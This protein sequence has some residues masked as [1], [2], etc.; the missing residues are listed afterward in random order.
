MSPRSHTRSSRSGRVAPLSELRFG[1][2]DLAHRPGVLRRVRR[3]AAVPGLRAG[4]VGVPE[5]EP[6]ELDVRLEGVAKGVVV[7]GFVS[8]R[9]TAD[10]SRCLEPVTGPFAVEV[11]ELFEDEAV[12]SETYPLDG[13]EIDLDPLVRDAVLL[14]L[15]PAPLCA[16]DCLGLCPTCGAD[17]NRQACDCAPVDDDPRWAALGELKFDP[18]VQGPSVQGP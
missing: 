16:D 11:H 12:E 9:W 1:V 13:E 10:C 17:R 5:G 8:G 6:V 18:S 14:T 7:E 4:D 3:D 15:P 2:A